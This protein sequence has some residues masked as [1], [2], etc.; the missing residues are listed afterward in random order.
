LF[1]LLELIS[2]QGS[3]GL[4]DKVIIAQASLSNFI[5]KVSPG[6]YKSLTKVDFKV[7]DS[8]I[9]QPIG[10]YGS[11]E[12]IID[13]FL[14]FDIVN[15]NQ[16]DELLASTVSEDSES[17]VLQ[18]GLYIAVPPN[19][20]GDE[21]YM[22]F[23]PENGTWKD[24]A[25]SA[26]RRNRIT[27]MR[28]LTKITHQII[29]LFSEEESKSFVWNTETDTQDLDGLDDDLDSHDR[30]FSFEVAKTLEQ[31][32]NVT[33]RDGFNVRVNLLEL[34]L[35][36]SLASLASQAPVEPILLSGET[37]QAFITVHYVQ[38]QL[39]TKPINRSY[40]K[41]SL[42]ELAS[43]KIELASHFSVNSAQVLLEAGLETRFAGFCKH[44]QRGLHAIDDDIKKL[45]TQIR[46]DSTTELDKG[47]RELNDAMLFE[48]L[49]RVK[50]VYPYGKSLEVRRRSNRYVIIELGVS[51]PDRISLK[52]PLEPFFAL[53]SKLNSLI[54]RSVDNLKL[55]TFKNTSHNFQELKKKLLHIEL[56]FNKF[57]ELSPE[58]KVDLANLIFAGENPNQAVHGDPH[59]QSLYGMAKK[60]LGYNDAPN[61]E[62]DANRRVKT[63]VDKNFLELLPKL[64]DCDPLAEHITAAHEM[65][66][67]FLQDQVERCF[68]KLRLEARHIQEVVVKVHVSKLLEQARNIGLEEWRKK[69]LRSFKEVQNGIPEQEQ[70]ERAPTD[71]LSEP[72]FYLSGHE[73]TYTNPALEYRI[74][75][76]EL[77]AEH[78]QSLQ[79]DSKF[80]PKPRF[81]PRHASAFQLPLGHTVLFAQI[82]ANEKILLIIDDKCG[83]MT[84]YMDSLSAIANAIKAGRWRK[85]I[86]QEKIGK[87]IIVAFDESKRMLSMHATSKAQL[88]IFVFDETFG[89]LQSWGHPVELGPWYEP[90]C[91][92]LH[93][94]FV[95]GMDEILLVD[96][97]SRGRIFSLVTQQFRPATITFHKIPIA[98]YP[99]PDGACFLAMFDEDDGR[100]SLL[101]FHWMTFGS[102]E[103]ISLD[104]P[105]L[106]ATLQASLTS[107]V[108][109]GSVHLLLLDTSTWQLS[110]T[111][112]DITKKA[113]E[114][115]FQERSHLQFDDGQQASTRN[116]CL[117][118]CHVDVWT[119]F[120]VLPAV[121]RRTE[122][123]A[124]AQ[125]KR[126]ICVTT[127]DGSRIASYFSQMVKTFQ[128]KT[129]K[130]T[131]QELAIIVD[132]LDF[133]ALATDF[134]SQLDSIGSRFNVG[135]WIVDILCLIP[136]HLAVT[137][138]NRFVPLKDGV[139]SAEYERSLLGAD[140]STVVDSISFGWYESIL[141]SYMSTKPVKVVSSMGEQS[142]GKSYSLNHLADT[143]FA[144]SAM[145]T[146]EGVW[147]SITPTDDAL[148]VALDFEGVHS[149]ERSAQEDTLLVLFNTAVSNLV[150]FRN[151]FA[152]SRDITGLF[153]SFQSSSTV[154]D[155][156]TNPGLFRSTLV[157]IIKDVLDSDKKEIVREFSLKFQKIVQDE[158]ESNFISRL[159]RGQLKIVPWPV[160]Q[161]K[162]FY[163]LFPAIK[164]QLDKQPVTHGSAGN[165]LQTMKTLMAKLKANDWRAISQSMAGHRA[166]RLL[167]M[168]PNAL[169]HG[170]SEIEPHPEPLKDLETDLEIEFDDSEHQL[171]L[172]DSDSENALMERDNCLV[173]VCQRWDNYHL[174]ASMNEK[175]WVQGLSEYIGLVVDARVRHVQAWISKNLEGFDKTQHASITALER[176]LDAN[177]INV[178]ANTE[179]CKQQC[180]S[181]QLLCLLNRR[182]DNR[183]H[184][185]LTSHKCDHACEF[186]DGHLDVIK[187][188]SYPAG[189]AGKHI[190][191]VEDHL[192]GEPC[193]LKDKI[194]CLGECTQVVGHVDGDHRCSSR[195]HACGMPCMLSSAPVSGK[196]R[197]G[198]CKRTCTVSS[199][200]PHEDHLCDSRGCPIKC[201]LCKRLCASDDH[202]HPLE[203]D[204]IH[205]CGEPH[206]CRVDCP[207]GICEIDTTPQ[208]IEATFTGR[209]ETFQYTKYSQMAKRL[210]CVFPIPAGELKH[211]EKHCHTRDP[212]PFHFC[213]KTCVYCGYYCTLPLGH[214]QQEHETSHGSMSKSQWAMEDAD[215]VLELKG[216]KFGSKDEG[217][218]MM[219]NLI[220]QDMGRHVHIDFC[221]AD[222]EGDGDCTGPDVQHISVRLN[223][224]PNRD[225][226]WITHDLFWKRSDPYSRDDKENF[227]RC[228][229]MCAGPEHLGTASNAAQPSYCTLPLF[230]P[231][232]VATNNNALG[233]TSHDGHYFSC[234]NPVVLQQAFHVRTLTT[235]LTPHS[236]SGSMGLQDRQPLPGTPVTRKLLPRHNDRL[237]AVYSSVYSFCASRLSAAV[238]G[239]AQQAAARRDAYS[240]LLF[241]DQT[242]TCFLNDF[243]STPDQLIDQLLPHESRGGTS[244]ELAIRSIQD[245]MERHWSAERQVSLGPV[246]IFLSDGESTINDQDM[247]TLCRKAITLGKPLSFHGVAFGTDSATLQRMVQIA[248]QIEKSAPRDPLLPLTA[249]VGSSFAEALDSVRLA[250][251]FLGIAESLKKPRG[252]LF[253]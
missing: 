155:P 74:C 50:H 216:R 11:R 227:A 97:Q 26:V 31:D 75:P 150:L 199:D 185:C 114:F 159:H 110:S 67:V 191:V 7:L 82:V 233:Y 60:L 103:G 238:G 151:N 142:V 16:A 111:V 34:K 2:E 85:V 4:V 61:F 72:S 202:L 100:R 134:V 141:Q 55:R 171:Y 207:Q 248:Q 98:L 164:T 137:R 177:V 20:S 73:K 124:S 9:V 102:G 148:L 210:E 184:N 242:D 113:T 195:V 21:L 51:G 62:Q 161:S 211:I 241:D 105:H 95:T 235:S 206:P 237:G 179:L 126:V 200:I 169:I 101:A 140:V 96:N 214:S 153:Q 76:L 12:S 203:E 57:P 80:V 99:T 84:V 223:P 215:V 39:I 17:E 115:T 109:R 120:P 176:S 129:C 132:S 54:D 58:K 172:S 52:D 3:G 152:L 8:F 6:A 24:D 219:C 181:C 78:R 117:L 33:L 201:Q 163:S 246:V 116:N 247:Q 154:F 68:D 127:H 147:M 27:F 166:H 30:M 224:E 208:S 251:T 56:Y 243:V 118:D 193:I 135:G 83:N 64:S 112:L 128:Q 32:E 131:G 123:T 173:A 37:S 168:L 218:P 70:P 18:P 22:V 175:E 46:A 23:W 42:K 19:S 174:R 239:Q 79:L 189:H 209:H 212:K 143:S 221:R 249:H 186:T 108:H 234:K 225:K 69:F 157:I 139:I 144:G 43:G 59:P 228:D 94:C 71:I 125:P 48:V 63:L 47:A 232:H 1:C 88:Y 106:D 205:L 229:S 66:R 122:T 15:Q 183:D 217:A 89:S 180:G 145:R 146:T 41:I 5:N 77:T 190:C 220:C 28:Y 136:I 250:E 231:P 162:Q 165:F 222:A 244:Y 36:N 44:E 196:L 160:I 253:V 213:E 38:P 188:C 194:G 167:S 81:N 107:F 236:R 204:A 10:V 156:A 104:I 182:H 45:E 14:E 178:K 92:V 29:C 240:V 90:G 65:T 40:N 149:I 226:D 119:R 91:Q 197:R 192:C 93:M 13:F 187:P 25:Q 86:K 35:G 158:Q 230:H 170:Y 138:E 87:E 49:R 245:I 53:Y 198:I 252:A 121:Q 133:G 130:P